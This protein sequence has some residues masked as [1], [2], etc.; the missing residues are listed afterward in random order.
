MAFFLTGIFFF[1]IRLY[2]GLPPWALCVCVFHRGATVHCTGHVLRVH[3]QDA[4][5]FS[6]THT[7]MVTD[8]ATVT[9][10]HS[11][12][13]TKVISWFTPS[14][15]QIRVADL[16]SWLSATCH[17]DGWRGSFSYEWWAL[18]L[19]TSV[20]HTKHSCWRR[21]LWKREEFSKIVLQFDSGTGVYFGHLLWEPKAATYWWVSC[22]KH[23]SPNGLLS[24]VPCT[25][26]TPCWWGAIIAESELSRGCPDLDTTSEDLLSPLVLAQLGWS[27]TAAATCSTTHTTERTQRPTQCGE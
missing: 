27:E 23:G 26:M 16:L 2:F 20:C 25:G 9:Q 22:C 1:S 10:T 7:C 13:Q 5:T 19:F 17:E 11:Y 15:H 18:A 4:Q 6:H 3:T 24:G 14:F 21:L 8:A 12:S